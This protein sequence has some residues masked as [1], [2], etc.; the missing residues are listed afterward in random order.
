V[1]DTESEFSDYQS[2]RDIEGGPQPG[3]SAVPRGLDLVVAVAAAII[4]SAAAALVLLG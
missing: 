3:R 2:A 1:S 4:L